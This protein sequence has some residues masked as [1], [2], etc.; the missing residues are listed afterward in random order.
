MRGHKRNLN[1]STLEIPSNK[2]DC[3]IYFDMI[4]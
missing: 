1:I 4:H 2:P 3:E